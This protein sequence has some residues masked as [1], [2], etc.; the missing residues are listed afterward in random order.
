ME[1]R[2]TPR[3]TSGVSPP[4]RRQ[5]CSGPRKPTEVAGP[6]HAKCTAPPKVSIP[7]KGVRATSS[8]SAEASN[9]R[10]GRNSWAVSY[11]HCRFTQS[12]SKRS[13][14]RWIKSF[15]CSGSLLVTIGS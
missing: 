2:K 14:K 15:I 4:A 11:H 3:F 8:Y 7:S 10:L 13:L 12:R 1:Q 5:G 6:E 9:M